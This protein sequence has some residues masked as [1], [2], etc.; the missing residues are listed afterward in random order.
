[1]CCPD[2]STGCWWSTCH[3]STVISEAQLW[4]DMR[5]STDWST[6]GSRL[7][8]KAS[9]NIFYCLNLGVKM[10]ARMRAFRIYSS[11]PQFKPFSKS[12]TAPKRSK[13]PFFQCSGN[14]YSMF[15]AILSNLVW[16]NVD[17]YLECLGCQLSGATIQI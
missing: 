5:L 9:S 15:V 8:K 10:T 16:I 13:M 14:Q 7:W 11:W 6:S 3:S 12:L 1:M 2:L 17:H 4:A